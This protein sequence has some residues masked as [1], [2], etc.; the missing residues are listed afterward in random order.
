MLE[1]FGRTPTRHGATV[2]TPVNR[3][4]RYGHLRPP[5]TSL[6]AAE[7]R[8]EHRP[9]RR[10][11]LRARTSPAETTLTSSEPCP[12]SSHHRR[13]PSSRRRPLSFTLFHC[14]AGLA[15]NAVPVRPREEMRRP[16]CQQQQASPSLPS[17]NLVHVNPKKRTVHSTMWTWCTTQC[18]QDDP[19]ALART[20]PTQPRKIARN[21]RR[22]YTG[23]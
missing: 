16:T 20:S 8:P 12:V 13:P 11:E 9:P 3:H 23:E 21:I 15:P 22:V 10:V 14:Q 18:L 2:V 1:P 6:V 4:R 7:S 17:M 19:V 5:G